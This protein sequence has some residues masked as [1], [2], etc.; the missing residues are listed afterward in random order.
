MPWDS[1]PW[2]TEG[3]AE[4]SSEVAR[5][6]A[7]AA[8]G[9]SEGI[10]G[11]A[12]L[13]V[14][15][16]GTPGAGVR[17]MTGACAIL[18]R[19]PGSAYQAYAARLPAADQISVAATGNSAR[20]DLIVARI[21]NPNSYGET[22]PQPSDPANGPYVFTRIISGVAR[23]TTKV[24]QVRPNDSAIT[25]ARIDIP[26]NTSVITQSMIKDLRE[27][28]NPR[29]RRVVRALR[30]VWENPDEVGNTIYPNWEEF[31]N[32]ARWGL[33]IPDWAT[34]ATIMATWAGLDQRNPRD[35][36]GHLRAVI[37]DVATPIT[38]Y[39]CDWSGSA[40]RFTFMGGGT[41]SIPASM[42]GGNHDVVLQGCRAE[43]ASL[44]TGVLEADGGASIFCDIEFV[45]DPTED[46]EI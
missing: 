22:W 4:H 33:D 14:K 25:L 45:E 18:N 31:P 23:T 11:N 28:A 6:L 15:A 27:M 2:F 44:G 32:G 20:S 46:G 24:K 34:S 37:G 13:Q 21:E 16:L 41:V 17:A 36:Y 42:R 8:F 1:V 3:E 19:A 10:I 9:G 39:N 40:Q 5:L 38:N 12:D 35:S 26:E 30:G 29:R 7:Y 43:N